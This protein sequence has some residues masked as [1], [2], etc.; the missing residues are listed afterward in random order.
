MDRRTSRLL[1]QVGTAELLATFFFLLAHLL[2][3][4]STTEL[5]PAGAPGRALARP[6][7]F[8]P[9]PGFPLLL[10]CFFQLPLSFFKTSLFLCFLSYLS[11]VLLLLLLLQVYLAASLAARLVAHSSHIH[12]CLLLP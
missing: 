6:W 2:A 3:L 8:F 4:P 12:L 7:F 10:F 5:P 1:L 11:C 9:P